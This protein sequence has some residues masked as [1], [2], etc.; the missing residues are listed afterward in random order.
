MKTHIILSFLFLSVF[1]IS[2][3][4]QRYDIVIQNGRIVDG[5]GN[6]W[7]IGDIGIRKGRITSI[8]GV[9]TR[10][11]KRVIDAQGQIVAPGFIDVH[12]H[13][14]GSII[15]RSLAENFLYDG[16]TTL[17]TGN[18]G[19]SELNVEE[20]FDTIEKNGVS[21]NIATLIG[22][23]TVRRAVLNEENRAPTAAEL[24]QMQELVAQAMKDGA[25]GLSTG[26][27]YVPGTF[28]E[29][30]EI[31]ALADVAADY[32]GVYASHIRNEDH[33]VFDAID[34]A[35]EIGRRANIPV[36]ISHYKITGKRS[37]GQAHE[38]TE[39][40]LQYR[41]EGI[42]VTVDQYPYTASS[43]SLAVLLPTW[44]LGGG[45]DSL[46]IRLE[47]PETKTKIEAEMRGM[48]AET[49]FGNYEYAVV[50][51]CNWEPSYNGKS[52]SEV[53]LM[54]GNAASL[55]NEIQTILEMM[56]KKERIQ[57]VYHKMNEEDVQHIIRFPYTMI[58]SDAGIPAFGRSAPHPRA[59]GTNARVLG[60]YVREQKVTNLEDAIRKMTSLPASRFNL[61]DRG[62]LREGM[63]ADIVIFDADKI[64]DKAT[65]KAPH[66]YAEGMSY[67]LVNGEPVIENGQHNQ[68]KPGQ[69]LKNKRLK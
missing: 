34:E 24:R 69:P 63:A 29:T 53:N 38:L 62:L 21:L 65:F 28:A 67:V 50:A 17:V 9:A 18:C 36:E 39:R 45:R 5:S 52:I 16:V 49:G 4:G 26:L 15:S 40:I 12:A 27:I 1:S 44:A 19:G 22:H 48:I 61:H 25:V 58:A 56:T 51:N 23:N 7:Y 37:W 3:F 59:Y 42:D 57:M 46:N 10:K 64:A 6:P 54:R 33:R 30:S 55:D 8:G 13:V 11:A 2:G 14:E 41:R 31:V 32:G 20:F 47:D 43:T 68:Q 66:A 35:V 60:R